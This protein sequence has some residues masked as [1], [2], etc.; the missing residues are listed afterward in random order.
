MAVIQTTTGPTRTPRQGG[1][2]AVAQF[3]QDERLGGQQVVGWISDPCSFPQPTVGMCWETPTFPADEKTGA[4]IDILNAIGAP[5]ALYG[6]VECFLSSDVDFDERANAILDQGSGRV[7]EDRLADWATLGTVLTVPTSLVD[8]LAKVEDE[9]DRIY[10]GRGLILINR[11]DAVRLHAENALVPG[12]DGIPTT[13]NGTPVLASSSVAAG[14]VLGVGA[15]KVLTGPS[16]LHGAPL[17][18]ENLEMWIAERVHAILVDC[19]IRVRATV[20]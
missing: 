8:A 16:I 11:G 19:S 14:T 13:I 2:E 6:G 9:L 7:I 15:V 10:L 17:Q 1:I 4:A 5:F 12:L 20:A 3:E 18:R